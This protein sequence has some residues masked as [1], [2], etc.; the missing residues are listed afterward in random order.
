M[1]FEQKRPMKNQQPLWA[2]PVSV[3]RDLFHDSIWSF[4]SEG[5]STPFCVG[6]FMF[7]YQNPVVV[8]FLALE[9]EAGPAQSSE[10]NDVD[11]DALASWKHRFRLVWPPSL[12]QSGDSW[13]QEPHHVKVLP[14]C[15]CGDKREIKSDDDW[16]AL[17]CLLPDPKES[18]SD[19]SAKPSAS[20]RKAFRDM[21]KEQPWLADLLHKPIL[22][23]KR[24]SSSLGPSGDGEDEVDDIISENEGPLAGRCD[25]LDLPGIYEELQRQR[26]ELGDHGA[27]KDFTLGLVGGRRS[28][29]KLGVAVEAYKGYVTLGGTAERFVR[30]YNTLQLSLDW[31][32]L[33]LLFF[34]CIIVMISLTLQH[35]MQEGGN[36]PSR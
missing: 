11:E 4:A 21:I 2:R 19:N 17:D 1:A 12:I 35:L 36:Q 20:D 13:F 6:K 27:R 32:L 26:A 29:E 30:L 25:P 34:I 14:S 28:H 18:A 24:S 9:L 10:I 3:S 5:S 23:I 7:A 31:W 33:A 16:Q 22:P 8:C 15:I